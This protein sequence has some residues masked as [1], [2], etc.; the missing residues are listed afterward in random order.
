MLVLVR[1][2]RT[3]WNRERRFVGRTDVPLDDVGRAQAR[4][5]GALLGEVAELRTSPLVR[6]T[7]TAALL[8][9]G[10]DASVDEAFIEL[11]YGELEGTEVASVDH[12]WWRA[13]REDPAAPM[14]GG[15]SLVELQARVDAAADALFCDDGQ[16]ARQEGVDVVVVS[17]VGPIKA[18]VAWALGADPGTT[19]RLRLHNGS[20]TTIAWGIA[21]PVLVNYNVL[22]RAGA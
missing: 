21:G 7:E 14:P 17:H 13:L 18:A 4:A 9:T 11:D 12:N 22:P 3:A 10:R 2:G 20:L 5:A 1:H 6:A 16:G 19:H 8:G 15:E